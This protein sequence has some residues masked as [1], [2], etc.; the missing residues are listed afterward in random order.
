VGCQIKSFTK[1]TF[2]LQ[3]LITIEQMNA[4]FECQTLVIK[5]VAL[6]TLTSLNALLSIFA[7]DLDGNVFS[8]ECS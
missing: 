4:K 1:T 8:K 2:S 3:I 7:F 5:N 6:T